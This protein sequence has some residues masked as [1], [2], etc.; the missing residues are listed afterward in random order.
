MAE[1]DG[2]DDLLALDD[3]RL[4]AML[5]ADTA[6][7]AD[8]LGPELEYTHSDGRSDTRESYLSALRS[9]ALRYQRCERESAAVSLHGGV[10]LL[11]G[12]LRLQAL[13]Q[14]QQ[15]GIR[16]HY[17]AVWLRDAAQAWQLRAW[18]STLV[19]KLP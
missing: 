17:L 13:D 3:L 4:R 9:G 11:Q 6:T 5:R 16:I 8:L 10:A 2:C 14:G 7:L 19:E 1:D 12:L 15:K 18:A